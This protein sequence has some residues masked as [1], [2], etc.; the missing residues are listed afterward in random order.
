M[1]E[2][3]KEGTTQIASS[4]GNSAALWNHPIDVHYSISSLVGWPRFHLEVW[5]IDEFDR[6]QL[7]GNS[8]CY[9]P[10]VDGEYK[11]DCVNWKPIGSKYTEFADRFLG[12][13]TKLSDPSVVTSCTDKFPL[14]TRSTGVVFLHL[15]ILSKKFKASGIVTTSS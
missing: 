15:Y 3:E 11:L 2:G 7:L 14:Q 13:T 9:V 12:S 1:L 8:L 6:H 4:R 5:H 10:T